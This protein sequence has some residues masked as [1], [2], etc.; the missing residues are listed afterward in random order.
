MFIILTLFMI[1]VIEKT[2][3]LMSIN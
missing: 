3:Y 2:G 1:I